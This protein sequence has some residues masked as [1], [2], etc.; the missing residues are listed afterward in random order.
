MTTPVTEHRIEV[1]KH[2]LDDR[3]AE[4]ER[5]VQATKDALDPAK[6]F[7]SPWVRLG[8]AA[9]IGV[10]AGYARDS[11]PMKTGLRLILTAGARALL[12]DAIER[13]A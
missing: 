7:A 8:L 2:N 5:R 1:A 9:V 6:L 11:G 3:L 13:A 12:R 4:L 10:A